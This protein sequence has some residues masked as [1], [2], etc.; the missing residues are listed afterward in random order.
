MSEQALIDSL[1]FAREG[2]RLQGEVAVAKLSRLEDVVSEPSGN[3]RYVL[4][5][6]LNAH[7]KPVLDIEVEVTLALSCQRCLGRI[8]F[9]LRRESQL[10]LV[11]SGQS[12]PE[13]G[14]E[15]A[16]MESIAA[17]DV[18]DVTDIVEQEVLLGLP[19]APVHSEG[20]CEP[21]GWASREE[22]ISPFADLGK[23]KKI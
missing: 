3:V 12:L 1:K 17:E 6:R 23:L 7:G 2:G 8:D 18:N 5:G 11:E 19:I 9:M 20:M 14:D 13:V 21:A 16:E 22:R 10:L 4:G 15:E